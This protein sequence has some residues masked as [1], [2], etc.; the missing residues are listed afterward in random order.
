MKDLFENAER[1]RTRA[2]ELR[3][4]AAQMSAR[5]A[6]TAILAIADTLE[7][8]AR[9]LEEVTLKMWRLRRR[10]ADRRVFRPVLVGAAG[11]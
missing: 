9:S 1:C 11:D 6:R 7:H 4:I 5:E 8:R 3:A 10:T 2:A